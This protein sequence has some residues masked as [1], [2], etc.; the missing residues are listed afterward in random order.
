MDVFDLFSDVYGREAQEDMS[1][2]DYLLACRDDAGMYHTAAERM[3]DAIG[4]PELVDTSTDPTLGRIFMNRT[5]KRYPAFAE[6]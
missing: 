4:E 3:I 1:L 5:I 6:F 2:H